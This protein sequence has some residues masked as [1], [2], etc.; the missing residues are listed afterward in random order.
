MLFL[1]K[2]L[3]SFITGG[4]IIVAITSL[5]ERI[6]P[7]WAGVMSALPTTLVV[8]VIFITIASD[9]QIAAHAMVVLPTMVLAVMAFALGFALLSP[10]GLGAALVGGFVPWILGALLA[11]SMPENIWVQAALFCVMYPL[12]ALYAG[13]LPNMRAPKV[14]TSRIAMIFRALLA[15]A[16]ISTVLIATKLGG[17]L[18]GG[19]FT[20]FPAAIS[21]T[22]FLM[23]RKHGA[24]FAKTI[25]RGIPHGSA[26]CGF[27]AVVFYLTA[28]HFGNVGGLVVGTLA[29]YL[30]ALSSSILLS[31]L[32]KRIHAK[33]WY[34]R[35]QQDNA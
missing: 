35:F 23:A 12:V 11:V 26:G 31:T 16:A 29:G 10:R 32:F 21:C 24:D 27:F 1:Y 28:P 18:W 2:L 8:G 34:E 13:T 6:S 22:L 20:G 7:R 15:G 9:I 25:A 19:V 14:K 17:P 33:S 4:L 30:A 5:A 3:A